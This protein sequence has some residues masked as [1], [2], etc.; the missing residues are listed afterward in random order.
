MFLQDQLFRYIFRKYSVDILIVEA[1]H[2]RHG[3]S[4]HQLIDCLFKN[5]FTLTKKGIRITVRLWA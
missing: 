4:H 3:V 5:V 2:E 1:L